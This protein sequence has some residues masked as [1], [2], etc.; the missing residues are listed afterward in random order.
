[1]NGRSSLIPNHCNP[2]YIPSDLQAKAPRNQPGSGTEQDNE[3]KFSEGYQHQGS[4]GV[5]EAAPEE[6]WIQS[7][8]MTCRRHS[9]SHALQGQRQGGTAVNVQD[10][11]KTA[12][13]SQA[14]AHGNRCDSESKGVNEVRLDKYLQQ[15]RRR[16]FSLGAARQ[17][18][19]PSTFSTSLLE[20][21]L[22][23]SRSNLGSGRDVFPTFRGIYI[24][25]SLLAGPPPPSTQPQ[26]TSVTSATLVTPPSL[27]PVLNRASGDSEMMFSIP[28]DP[29]V[30]A[31]GGSEQGSVMSTPTEPLEPYF[32][33][34]RFPDEQRLQVASGAHGSTRRPPAS[35]QWTIHPLSSLHPDYQHPDHLHSP[36]MPS[37]NEEGPAYTSVNPLA[38]DAIQNVLN[39]SQ[40]GRNSRRE[41]RQTGH[42]ATTVIPSSMSSTASSTL[43]MVSAALISPGFRIIT[44]FKT[45]APPPPEIPSIRFQ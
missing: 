22:R 16:P 37:P 9:E 30:F 7:A 5:P 19:V 42:D 28:P 15:R 3:R 41:S 23:A 17:G 12:S 6:P 26:R 31:E 39:G 18:L 24:P 4:L 35:S 13:F 20:S 2:A 43:N 1:V 8:Y 34:Y 36:A 25:E 33:E 45:S 21:R 27:S 38:T 44:P 40:D 29:L 32:E 14:P 11:Q 10:I